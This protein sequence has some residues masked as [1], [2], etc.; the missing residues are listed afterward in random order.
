M[1]LVTCKSEAK[2]RLSKMKTTHMIA[3]KVKV[4]SYIILCQHS[5]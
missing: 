5:W 2:I 1:K 4:T 3:C